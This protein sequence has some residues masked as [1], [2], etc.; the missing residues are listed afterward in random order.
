MKLLAT[1]LALLSAADVHASRYRFRGFRQQGPKLDLD[2]TCDKILSSEQDIATSDDVGDF[3]KSLRARQARKRSRDEIS[4]TTETSITEAG[5]F[6]GDAPRVILIVDKSGSMKGLTANVINEFNSFLE[7]LKD[8]TASSATR[9]KLSV[10]L[11]SSE[12]TLVSYSDILDVPELTSDT[13]KPAG[14]TA[15]FASITC[16]LD[17]FADE[18]GNIVEVF[19]DGEDRDGPNTVIDADSVKER[20]LNLRDNQDWTFEFKGMVKDEGAA[21]QLQEQQALAMGF[22]LNNT[23]TKNPFGM[24]KVWTTMGDE[25]LNHLVKQGVSRKPVNGRKNDFEK[26]QQVKNYCARYPNQ[27]RCKKLRAQGRL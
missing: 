16:L 22:T 27:K 7:R 25:V 20:L 3:T 4:I 8:E 17:K 5:G 10:A 21:K 18:E 2:E 19:T 12:Y 26:F 14:G 6:G 13:Y 24:R 9:V 15:L 1:A 11:F 23:F